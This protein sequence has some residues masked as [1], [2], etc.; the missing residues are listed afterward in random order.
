MS[1]KT[2]SYDRDDDT[3]EVPIS[4]KV[5]CEGTEQTVVFQILNNYSLSNYSK[6]DEMKDRHF[7]YVYETTK[8][9]ENV[10]R[11]LLMVYK[12]RSCK[13][14]VLQER[15]YTNEEEKRTFWM[16]KT[17]KDVIDDLMKTDTQ[18]IMG[19]CIMPHNPSS[20]PKKQLRHT[21]FQRLVKCPVIT[22]MDSKKGLKH[23]I[24]SIVR[25]YGCRGVRLFVPLYTSSAC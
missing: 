24:R 4:W 20:I 2:R 12:F 3:K 15:E 19:A 23:E 9:N 11:T 13:F 14:Q 5:S 16:S 10:S 8:V 7:H 18:I 21:A 22:H 17:I 25:N 6:F 1:I